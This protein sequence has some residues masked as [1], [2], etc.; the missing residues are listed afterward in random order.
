MMASP[1]MFNS[2]TGLDIAFKFL[3][4]ISK[5][6]THGEVAAAMVSALSTYKRRLSQLIPISLSP[7][8]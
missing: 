5:E 3:H 6:A 8:L 2:C 7:P 4:E 1:S